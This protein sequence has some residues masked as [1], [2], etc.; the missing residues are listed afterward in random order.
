MF[1]TGTPPDLTLTVR[2]DNVRK[3]EE[4]QWRLEL[5]NDAG[6]GHVDFHLHVN[7]QRR[8]ERQCRQRYAFGVFVILNFLL[9]VLIGVGQLL[10]YHAVRK[11]TMASRT[12]RRKQDVAIARRLSLIVFTDFCCWFPIGLMGLLASYD[13]PI[14]GE[15][16]VWA[17]IFILPVNSA[18]NPFLYTLSMLV[19]R[20]LKRREERH[21]E[22]T[23]AKLHAD[24]VTWSDTKVQELLTHCQK[25]L[26]RLRASKR[27]D[28]RQR[29]LA[30]LDAPPEEERITPTAEPRLHIDD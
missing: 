4:G 22:R 5:T 16:N 1:V 18:I 13:S 11:T 29:C 12:T 2:L 27:V 9:F 15:V 7:E 25:L 3:E 24:M 17:A 23:L 10:I 20:W 30:P 8:S 14:P 28:T 19:E 21:V 6:T 26:K